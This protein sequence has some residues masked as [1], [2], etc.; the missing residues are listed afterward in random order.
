MH[1]KTFKT[2][3]FLP[4]NYSVYLSWR[5]KNKMST[6]YLSQNKYYRFCTSTFSIF[7][8]IKPLC[9]IVLVFLTLLFFLRKLLL[10]ATLWVQFRFQHRLYSTRIRKFFFQST[11]IQVEHKHTHTQK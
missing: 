6:P 11:R 8:T 5:I 1:L 7:S 9:L 10:A 4:E 3:P 2:I